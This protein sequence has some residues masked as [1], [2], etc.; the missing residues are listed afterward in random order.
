MTSPIPRPGSLKIRSYISGASSAS[1][2]VEVSKLSSNESAL[3]PSPAAMKAYKDA[4]NRI[5]RYPDASVYELRSSLAKAHNID[6]ER[7]VCGDGSDEL[8]QLL[9]IGYSGPGDDVLYT[10][11]GFIIY[12]MVAHAAGSNPI[13]VKEKDYKIDVDE[14]INSVTNKTKIVFIANPNSTGTY[15]PEKDILR[16][17]ANLPETVLLVIDAA[18][19]EFANVKDY[20]SGVEL[21]RNTSNTVM[22][23]TFSKAYGLA[24]LRLGWCFAPFPI[25]NVLN[26]LRGPFNVS[27]PAQMAGVA[28]LNDRVYLENVRDYNTKWREWLSNELLKLGILVIPSSANFVLSKFKGGQ[29]EAMLVNDFLVSSGILVREMAAYGLP[30]CLR[31]TVGTENDLKR[32]I[33]QLKLFF[34]NTK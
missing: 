15:L 17:H 11:F 7:I 25:A 6:E 18:Y 10:E 14:I 34:G 8:L 13:P 26:R 2:A 19:A 23:R 20:S 3:G 4:I 29:K 27:L 28:A 31:I 12:P 21:V 22:T 30:D 9:A 1:G 5:Y 16:L 24:G 32:L 33:D